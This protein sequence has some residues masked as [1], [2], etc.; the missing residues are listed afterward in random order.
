MFK[1]FSYW[2]LPIFAACCWLGTLLGMLGWWLASGSPHLDGMDPG[3]RIAYISDIGATH[4]QPLFIAG[5]AVT[6]IVFDLCF[7]SERW[8]RHKGRL[9]HNTSTTQKVLSVLSSVFAIIGAIGL[10]LLTCLKDT[11]FGTAHD[12]CL[13]IFIVGYIISAIFACAEYQRL[14]IHFRQY[15]ILRASFWIKLFFI[16]TE[17]ALA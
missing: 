13:V 6:V 14:G 12:T 11:K 15:R 7:I 5:S 3:Q 17:I 4:L 8:L 1:I 9:A 16:L 2:M 10:I